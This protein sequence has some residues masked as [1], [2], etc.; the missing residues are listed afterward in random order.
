[1]GVVRDRKRER[2]REKRGR[3]TPTDRGTRTNQRNAGM[4]VRRIVP[5]I[6]R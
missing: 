4:L 3:R 6:L 2:E 1:M 5:S